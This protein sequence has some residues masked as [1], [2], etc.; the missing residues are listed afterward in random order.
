[1]QPKLT[2]VQITDSHIGPT[3]QFEYHDHRPL[4]DL[5]RVIKQINSFPQPPDFVI[6][7]GDIAHDQSA[8]AITL[9][10]EALAGLNVPV[11]VVNGNHDDPALLRKLL[12]ALPPASGDLGAPLDY[13]FEIKGERFLVLDSCHTVVPDPQGYLSET[14]LALIRA[15]T[16]DDGPPLT[17]FVHHPPFQMASPWLDENMIIA[18][19]EA[20]HAA[21]L[22]ARDRL[23]GVFYGHLHRSCQVMRDG[24]TYTCA[25]GTAWQYTWRPWDERPQVDGEYGSGYNVVHLLDNRTLV[26][27]YVI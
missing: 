7:T 10:G 15:E 21:L 4:R 5:E 18:N 17:V 8:E 14:Q 24:I 2:F 6:H 16:G 11:Y 23:R 25:A 19:G 1:M 12:D 3:R 26:Y 27:Q 9:A 22:P 20:L 13:V